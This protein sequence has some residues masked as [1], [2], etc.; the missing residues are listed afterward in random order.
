MNT[1]SVL[2]H[3]LHSKLEP[4]F[5]KMLPEFEKNMNE[6]QSY[7]LIL[8][9]LIIMRR[10]FRSKDLNAN[11]SANIGTNYKR[12]LDIIMGALNHEYSKVVSEGLRVAGSFVYVLRGQDGSSLDPKFNSVIS[13]LYEAVKDKL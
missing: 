2:A 4:Y 3:A 9:T 10:I 5:A 8:D 6:T 11:T 12:V 7:D 13:P 1:L